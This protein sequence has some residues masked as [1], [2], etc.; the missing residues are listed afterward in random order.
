MMKE[1]FESYCKNNGLEYL[2]DEWNSDKNA[3]LGLFPDTIAP[4]SNKKAWWKCRN[5]GNTWDSVISSR[6]GQSQCGCPYCSNEKLLSGFNDLATKCPEL[7]DEWLYEKNDANG[8]FPD[9]ILHGTDKKVWWKCK[10][11][12]KMISLFKLTEWL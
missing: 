7:L 9:K 3:L 11:G 12:H 6:T 10:L 5:C 8:I 1:T 2:I 4:K